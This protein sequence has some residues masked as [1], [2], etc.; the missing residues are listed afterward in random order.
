MLLLPTPQKS[1]EDEEL[2]E[3]F[4]DETNEDVTKS[5]AYKPVARRLGGSKKSDQNFQK[6]NLRKKQFVRGKV[7][8]EQK[9][10]M[11]RKQMFRKK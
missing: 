6:I 3:A 5:R 8:A 10:K 2:A 1:E 4:D 11:K 7:T 9:R